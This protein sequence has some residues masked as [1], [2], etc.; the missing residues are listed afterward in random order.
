MSVN[1]WNRQTTHFKLLNAIAK[2]AEEMN[3]PR[4]NDLSA[5]RFHADLFLS[6]LERII[7]VRVWNAGFLSWSNSV[8]T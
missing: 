8:G 1:D 2:A 7:L 3:V 6:G 4:D 5:Y